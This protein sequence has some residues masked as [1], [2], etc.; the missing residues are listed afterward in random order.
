MS[1]TFKR[2]F[3]EVPV[4]SLRTLSMFSGSIA[5]PTV[6]F[7]YM[8]LCDEVVCVCVRKRKLNLNSFDR[9]LHTYTN[10]CLIII[11]IN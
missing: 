6:F 10:A 7:T 11:I 4:R 8:L 5:F 3:R 1:F 9:S 2:V